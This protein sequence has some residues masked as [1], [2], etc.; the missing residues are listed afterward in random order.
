MLLLSFCDAFVAIGGIIQPE[1]SVVRGH[2]PRRGNSISM[3]QERRMDGEPL[4]KFK[5]KKTRP[6]FRPSIVL[7]ELICTARGTRPVDMWR[8]PANS[9]IVCPFN[10][11]LSHLIVY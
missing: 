7:G 1:E 9:A 5:K 6:T 3:Q 2:T 11:S 4:N 10:S 8:V